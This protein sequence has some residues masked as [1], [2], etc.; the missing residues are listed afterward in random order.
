MPRRY[1]T[2]RQLDEDFNMHHPVATLQLCVGLECLIFQ[3]LLAGEVPQS[4]NDFLNHP[5]CKFVTVYPGITKLIREYPQLQINNRRDLNSAAV[6][7]YNERG[8][9]SLDVMNLAIN[10]LGYGIDMSKH[11]EMSRWDDSDLFGHQ[12]KYA[13]IQTFLATEIAKSLEE[14]L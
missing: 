4:L 1:Q 2:E 12:I 7:K 8:L 5:R 9:Y 6:A 11:A 14:F 13:C 10:V 3:L